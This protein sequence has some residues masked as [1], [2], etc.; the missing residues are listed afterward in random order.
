MGNE[1]RQKA[2]A[3]NPHFL[4]KKIGLR[5]EEGSKYK[6]YRGMLQ[7]QLSEYAGCHPQ[8]PFPLS[9]ETVR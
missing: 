7:Q 3:L 9:K 5:G 8:P 4:K 6:T 2:R 1:G